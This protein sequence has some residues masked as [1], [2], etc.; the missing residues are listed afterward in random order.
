MKVKVVRIGMLIAGVVV[1]LL[2]LEPVSVLTVR[3]PLQDFHPV[4]AVHV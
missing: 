2:F 4:G 3:L 1:A